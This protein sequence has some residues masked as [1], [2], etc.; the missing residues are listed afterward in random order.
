ML[1]SWGFHTTGQRRARALV[2]RSLQATVAVP[3]Q[4][5]LAAG[6]G[7][8]AEALKAVLLRRPFSHGCV[9]AP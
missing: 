5:G 3:I 1:F 9:P 2:P 8:G 7:G 4:F 6:G